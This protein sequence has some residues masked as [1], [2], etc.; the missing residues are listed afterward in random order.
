MVWYEGKVMV[1]LNVN[2]EKRT[3]SVR[4][5]DILLDV[6]RD[7]LGL[8]GAKPGCRNG[9]CGACT[10]IMDGWPIKSCLVL[11]VEAAGH[12]ILTVEGLNAKAP[13]QKA[14]IDNNAFQCGYC[15]S[16]FL[17]V[18]HALS[19]QFPHAEE[20][21]IEEWLQSNLCRCTSYQEIRNA[22]R[23]IIYPPQN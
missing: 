20:Y 10:V 13:V 22:V 5:A 19:I 9:D 23:S 2:G 15:T 17:M 16:G 3:V 4:P 21:V 6:L 7:Q 18:C 12:N 14:F 11:A 1:N 8:T